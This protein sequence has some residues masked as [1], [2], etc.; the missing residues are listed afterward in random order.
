MRNER[1][2]GEAAAAC[3]GGL[4]ASRPERGLEDRQ[5]DLSRQSLV[6]E[7]GAPVGDVDGQIL[8]RELELLQ[9]AVLEDVHF[10]EVVGSPE[11]VA[12][13]ADVADL[14]RPVAP[15]LPLVA[16][17]E[18]IDVRRPDVGIDRR[19]PALEREQRLVDR[20]RERRSD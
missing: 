18:V 9:E 11:I 6:G 3:K 7:A 8:L 4:R 19:V 14:E 1:A 20:E 2:A 5:R 17:A 15:Q 10:V 13:I 16:D 12:T